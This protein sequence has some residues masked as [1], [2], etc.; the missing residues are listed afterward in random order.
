MEEAKAWLVYVP[1]SGGTDSDN[2]TA[3]PAAVPAIAK[4]DTGE[5]QD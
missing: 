3:G 2:Q 4:M 1:V 5:L